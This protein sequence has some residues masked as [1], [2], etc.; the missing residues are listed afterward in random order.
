MWTNIR[1]K[2]HIHMVYVGTPV[3]EWIR[4]LTSNN[5]PLIALGSNSDRDFDFFNV[6]KHYPASLG[7]VGGSTQVP[8][9]AWNN[10]Q[11]GTLGLPPPVKLESRNI[12]YCV[13]MT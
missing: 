1:V 6:R 4:S 3:V 5:L 10:A 7:N 9:R 13:G 2:K 12:L 11:R 8:V